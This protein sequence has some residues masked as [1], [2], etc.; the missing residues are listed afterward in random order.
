M[1]IIP[2]DEK[3]FMVDRRTNT[4]YGGS[5]ALQDMQQWYTMQD[6]IDTVDG[7]SG[8][9]VTKV[10]K[11]TI[12]EAQVLQLFTT[13]ITILDSNDPL[14]VSYPISVYIKRNNGTPYTLA[15]NS[16]TVINDTGTAMTGTLVP[17][18]LTNT[19]GYFQASISVTQNASGSGVYKN[20]LYKLKAGTGNPTLGTGSL[21]VYVTYIEITL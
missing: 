13:P 12:T 4:V 20:N 8:S 19:E 2:A 6:V 14:K 9:Q 17:N 18:P 1:A 5:Q 7:G 10:L 15:A 3:V 21:D 16:F 11:T